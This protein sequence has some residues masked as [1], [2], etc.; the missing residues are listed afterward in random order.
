M[1]ERAA[2]SVTCPKCSYVR[3]GTE[4]APDW[5]CPRCGIAYHKYP[6]YLERAKK[7]VTPPSAEDA[8]PGWM[9]DG[10]VWSLVAANVLSLVIAFSQDWSTLSLMT[11]YWGQSVI[12]G[13]ANVFRILALDRFSTENFTINKRPVEPTTG[14]K[15]QVAGFF[16]VHYGFF[17]MVYMVFLIAGAETDIG[18]FDPWFLMCLGAFALNHYWSYRYNRDLDRQGT[19]N[20]G[21]LMFT[22]YLRIVPMHLTIIFGGMTLNTGKSLLLFG[23]FKTLADA[24]MHLVEHAQIKKVRD[25]INQGVVEI[26]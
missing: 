25:S 20:I 23:V 4:T 21:T 3:T 18:L 14:T 8:A 19:P 10:S 12:I 7:I 26:K 2:L 15:I 13:I 16:A 5:Q 17:H 9:E 24:G 1:S 11:L 22:P 6:S